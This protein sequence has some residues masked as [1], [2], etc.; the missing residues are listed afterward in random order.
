[1]GKWKKAVAALAAVPM[2]Q[3]HRELASACPCRSVQERYGWFHQAGGRFVFRGRFRASFPLHQSGWSCDF[4]GDQGQSRL[5][6]VLRG[7]SHGPNY[8]AASVAQA[9]ADLKASKASGPSSMV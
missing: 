8:D 3:V 5:H 2:L 1:M 6:L 7:S 9:L 4:R